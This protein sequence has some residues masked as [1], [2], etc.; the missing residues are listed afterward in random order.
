MRGS[1]RSLRAERLPRAPPQTE[2]VWR[3]AGGPCIRA[4]RGPCKRLGRR[5]RGRG[6]CATRADPGEAPR[7]VLL[8]VPGA[9]AEAPGR[10]Q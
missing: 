9:R 4:L 5:V 7:A 2:P 6:E 1:L 3:S 8:A 10:G